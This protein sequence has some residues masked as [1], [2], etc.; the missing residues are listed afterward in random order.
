MILYQPIKLIYLRTFSHKKIYL[1]SQKFLL[2]FT[3]LF[4]RVGGGNPYDIDVLGLRYVNTKLT[5]LE[6]T[7]VNDRHNKYIA[8]KFFNYI[9]DEELKARY[10]KIGNYDCFWIRNETNEK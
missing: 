7:I 5:F 8:L 4:F 10:H 1:P 2:Y 9:F 3:A 6:Y